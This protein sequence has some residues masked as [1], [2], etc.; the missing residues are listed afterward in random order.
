MR[1]MIIVRASRAIIPYLLERWCGLN[2]DTSR[3]LGPVLSQGG[4]FAFVLFAAGAI[5]GVVGEPM[6]NLLKL[7]VTLSMV[8]TSLL[9][10]I[11]EAAS[12]ASKP[13]PPPAQP[14]KF[15]GHVD[16]VKARST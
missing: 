13:E 16:F 5:Q 8:A 9:L 7:A 14:K 10:F 1:F 4:E 15:A 2:G 11:A 3:R 6:V 12:R